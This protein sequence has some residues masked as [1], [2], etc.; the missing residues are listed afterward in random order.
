MAVGINTP[1]NQLG[2]SLAAVGGLVSNI[3]PEQ[4]AAPTPCTDWTVR[5]LVS[6]LVGM[7]R[8]FA[9]LLADEPPP[10]RWRCGGGPCASLPG[11]SRGAAGRVQ[12][13][14]SSRDDPVRFADSALR[15]LG[16]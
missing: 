16:R 3:R 14:G 15:F 12:P 5:E 10:R 11:V 1:L 13:A 9:A 4:W 8:V 7:N 6:H 2:R